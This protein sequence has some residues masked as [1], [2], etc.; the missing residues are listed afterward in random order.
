MNKKKIHKILK[1]LNV[2]F[3]EDISTKATNINC[4]FCRSK[5]S[6]ERDD[7]FHLGIFSNGRAFCLRCDHKGDLYGVLFRLFGTSINEYKVLIGTRKPKHIETPDV[8]RETL[9]EKII[10]ETN[11]KPQPEPLPSC[12]RITH[13][14]VE[15]R[16]L[17]SEFLFKRD[18]DVETC[19]DNGARYTGNLGEYAH[20]LVIPLWEGDQIMGYQAR[21]ITGKS[22]K[23]YIT[24]GRVSDLL[25]WSC[26]IE[27]PYRVYLV[28]GVFDV[29]RMGHSAVASFSHHL[30][31]RQ[32]KLLA[33]DETIKE[34]IVCWDADSYNKS[35]RLRYDLSPKMTG[36]RLGV[37][38]LP[39][40]EDPD[41]LGAEAVR[42]LEIE[43]A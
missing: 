18:I 24:K 32:Q 26:D 38:R 1:D 2:P 33:E 9:K 7:K 3:V 8:I 19:I 15:A 12:V 5:K 40:G 11:R 4:P 13:E 34:L 10:E 25:Y 43:W 14:L 17:L 21:D 31:R 28:E 30:S 6:G 29:W 35:K 20:R 22:N 37:V 23:R 39:E 41:S 16:T 27:Y 36:V 42:G